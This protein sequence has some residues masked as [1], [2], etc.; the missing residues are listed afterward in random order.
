MMRM[1]GSGAK[2]LCK[3]LQLIGK[4]LLTPLRSRERRSGDS[5]S[6]RRRQSDRQFHPARRRKLHLGDLGLWDT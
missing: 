5:D 3:E 1:I 2:G 4:L 6:I